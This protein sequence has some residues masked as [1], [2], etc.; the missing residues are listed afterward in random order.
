[1]SAQL[2]LEALKNRVDY[3]VGQYN[4]N[5][6]ADHT[7]VL[8]QDGL[9]DVYETRLGR[10]VFQISKHSVSTLPKVVS[11]G[12]TSNLSQKIPYSFFNDMVAWFRIVHEKMKTEVYCRIYYDIVDN[13]F[14]IDVPEQ[15]VAS[16]VA[17]WK[18]N[19]NDQYMSDSERYILVM[20]IHSHHTMNGKFSSIDD[21]DQQDLDGLHMVIGNID[22]ESPSYQLRYAHGNKKVN[23]NLKDIFEINESVDLS[24]FNGWEEKVKRKTYK[25]EFKP[26]EYTGAISTPKGYISDEPS[27]FDNLYDINDKKKKSKQPKK[28]WSDDV[29]FR[30]YDPD[31]EMMIPDGNGNVIPL[32]SALYSDVF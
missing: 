11:V 10:F 29:M 16:A 14:I 31:D 26:I 22:N 28:S 30:D 32:S 25:S 15:E 23:L 21:A 9:F 17:V 2:F 12:F 27:L 20:Q 5:Q 7:Y 24:H 13:K 1:M 18:L 8:Q 4:F 19:E 6:T 3:Q